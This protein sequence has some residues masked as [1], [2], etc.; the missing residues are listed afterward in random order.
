MLK[1]SPFLCF[2]KEKKVNRFLDPYSAI[3]VFQSAGSLF[4][5]GKVHI[6]M[7]SSDFSG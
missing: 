3:P 2:I 5:A 6:S 1:P 4:S 7:F